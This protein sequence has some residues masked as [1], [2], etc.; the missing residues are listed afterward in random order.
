MG[1]GMFDDEP[2]AKGG[3]APTLGEPLDDV[4]VGELDERILLLRAEIER[5]EVVKRAKLAASDRA[6]S[7][8]KS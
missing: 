2:R 6:A 1:P 8:F 5:L 4:S 3:R 7:I